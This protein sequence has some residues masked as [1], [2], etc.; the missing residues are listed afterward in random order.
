MKND[1]SARSF[2]FGITGVM[3]SPFAPV[4]GIW[5]GVMGMYFDIEEH[6][7]GIE[8]RPEKR[9]KMRITKSMAVS[10]AAMLL[11]ALLFAVQ[12]AF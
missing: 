4:A 7:N 2:I 1:L 10:I 5:F 12:R 8:E 11:S 9:R 3:V 6:R